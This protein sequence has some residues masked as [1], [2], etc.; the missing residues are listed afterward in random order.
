[1]KLFCIGLPKTGTSSMQKLAIDLGLKVAPQRRGE[2][3]FTKHGHAIP[4]NLLKEHIDEYEFFQDVPFNIASYHPWI[5]ETYPDARFILTKR[6]DFETWFS[7]VLRYYASRS[8]VDHV[9]TPKDLKSVRHCGTT[10][11]HTV[12]LVYGVTDDNLFCKNHYRNLY[13]SY[14]KQV[15][16]IKNAEVLTI[17]V[18]DN[19][20]IKKTLEF[21]G[22]GD[23][24]INKFPHV[25]KTPLLW[26]H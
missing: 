19:A 3:L 12:K 23:A 24:N 16:E 11:L 8:G 21:M 20:C 5:L 18:S 25:N 7:S 9:P 13:E 17:D 2:V 6:R 22:K 26:V 14:H 4:K 10:L 1:M 15:D